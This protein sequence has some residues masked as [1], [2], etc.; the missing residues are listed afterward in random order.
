MLT[1]LFESS[2]FVAEFLVFVPIL[3][4]TSPGALPR[5]FAS[6]TFVSPCFLTFLSAMPTLNLPVH[7]IGQR[8]FFGKHQKQSRPEWP[9]LA[10]TQDVASLLPV[11]LAQ[12]RD[13]Q[14]V[15]QN[16]IQR[17][18]LELQLQRHGTVALDNVRCL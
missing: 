16:S 17:S 4:L 11:I 14:L 18:W 15:Y 3:L 5:D 12:L 9:L 1:H 2:K 7:Y 13:K 8:E 10:K 6:S